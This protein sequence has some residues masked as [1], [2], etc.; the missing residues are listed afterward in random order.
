LRR[1]DYMGWN[2]NLVC[3]ELVVDVNEKRHTPDAPYRTKETFFQI[4][5]TWINLED[6]TYYYTMK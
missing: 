3:I 1:L 2:S 4:K 6:K 5:W